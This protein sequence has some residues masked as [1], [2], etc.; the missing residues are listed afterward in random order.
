MNT[1]LFDTDG[2]LLTEEELQKWPT[3]KPVF[4]QSLQSPLSDSP[5]VS[6]VGYNLESQAMLILSGKFI[7]TLP[8]FYANYWV[9]QNRM[10][11]LRPKKFVSN[12]EVGV[13]TRGKI[14]AQ[15]LVGAFVEDLLSTHSQ[16][17]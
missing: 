11:A 1:P 16:E 13:I 10:R 2:E 12:L 17:D 15:S 14:E 7:G 5:G 8:S 4:A 6:A 3:V 9:D